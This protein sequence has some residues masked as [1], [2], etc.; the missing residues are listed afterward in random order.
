MSEVPIKLTQ[1]FMV[2][3]PRSRE[4][5]SSNGQQEVGFSYLNVCALPDV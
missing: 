3:S 2:S 1:A 5:T 4:Q